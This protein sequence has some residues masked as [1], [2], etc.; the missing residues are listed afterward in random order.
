M[1]KGILIIFLVN[2]GC[3]VKGKPSPPL[4]PPVLCRGEPSYSKATEG[5]KI[6]PKKRKK[7]QDDWDESDDFIEDKEQ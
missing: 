5:L 1:K 6:D 7:I 2:L 4:T 3:G